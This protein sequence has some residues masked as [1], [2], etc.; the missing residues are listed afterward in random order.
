M[1]MHEPHIV[2]TVRRM[3]GERRP[4][5]EIAMAV[6]LTEASLEWLCHKHGIRRSTTCTFNLSTKLKDVL[7]AEARRRNMDFEPFM[8][9]LLGTIVQP[10]PKKPHETL[11]AAILDDGK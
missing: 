3:K 6:G 7:R 4:N 10:N 11:F 2:E 5:A 8:R 9:K 1:T